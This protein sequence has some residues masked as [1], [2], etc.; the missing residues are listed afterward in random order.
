[1]TCFVYMRFS[2]ARLAADE[3]NL[4][5]I[6]L[7]LIPKSRQ[8]SCFLIAAD[9]LLNLVRLLRLETAFDPSFPDDAAG[10]HRFRN[11]SNLVQLLI[12]ENKKA[13]KEFSCA[14]GDKNRIRWRHFA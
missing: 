11:V 12:L 8:L 13:A 10:A 9:E 4:S 6:T 1:Q 3:D 14:Q 7:T 2:Y 5:L